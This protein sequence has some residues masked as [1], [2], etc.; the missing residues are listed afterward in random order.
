MAPMLAA[1]TILGDRM[2]GALEV[3]SAMNLVLLCLAIVVWVVIAFVL[4]A[5]SNRWAASR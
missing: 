1:L 5:L 2:R 3:P 4:Q